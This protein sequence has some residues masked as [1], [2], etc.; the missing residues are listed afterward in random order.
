MNQSAAPATDLQNT[1]EEYAVILFDGVCNMCNASV[2]YV[3]DHD[4]QER[5]RFASLQSEVG[6]QLASEHGI[7]ASELSSMVLMEQ[8]KAYVRS[9]AVLKVCRRLRGPAKLLWPFV[10]LPSTLRDP[11]YRFVANRRY[12][13]FGKKDAC[14]LPTES[15]RAR[16]L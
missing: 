2:N 11:F 13:W 14:R 16:F 6:H 8:G 3:M 1:R 4:P 10:L 7:D 12:K 15:D 5:F 9:T